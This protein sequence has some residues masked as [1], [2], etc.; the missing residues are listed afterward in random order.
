M[1]QWFKKAVFENYANFNGRARRSEYWYFVLVFMILVVAVNILAGVVAASGSTVLTLI[2][3][4]IALVVYLGLLVP[5]IS[6]AVRRMHDVGKSG[7]YCLIPIYS[8]ILALTEGEKGAN[9]YGPDPKNNTES[10]EEI[11]QTQE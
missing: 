5:S 2:F 8:L 4:G 1:I 3:S 9:A 7:W 10:I 6:V 11:G